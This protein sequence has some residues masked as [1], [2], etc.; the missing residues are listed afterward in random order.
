MIKQYTLLGLVFALPLAVRAQAPIEQPTVVVSA[1][2]SAQTVDAALASVTVIDRAAIEASQAPDLLELL[3]QVPGVDINRPGG[4]GQSTSFL[5]RG[6][7]SN[8]VLVL[9][10]GVRVASANTGAFAFEHID[11][12][13]LLVWGD[14]DRMVTHKGSRHILE[15]LP[16]TRYELIEGCGHCPQLETPDRVVDALLEFA[17]V[18]A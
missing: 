12:P 4:P 8:H 16:A 11:V 13:V 6:T 17:P 2:R 14:R 3:R 1:T 15:A 7:N 9:I 5:L 18:P 10:D